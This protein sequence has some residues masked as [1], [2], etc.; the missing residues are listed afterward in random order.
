MADAPNLQP[1]RDVT[2][3]LMV[4][5][6]VLVSP[7]QTRKLVASLTSN[8]PESI[9]TKS[10]LLIPGKVDKWKAGL[11]AALKTRDLWTTLTELPP[12]IVVG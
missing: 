6:L 4:A 11:I 5:D 10:D 1:T 12:T 3:T 2:S 7:Y 8:W 9:D